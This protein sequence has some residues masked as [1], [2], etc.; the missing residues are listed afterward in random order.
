ML[1]SNVLAVVLYAFVGVA[2]FGVAFWLVDRL[3]PGNM[4][5]ELVEHKNVALGN[6]LAGMAIALAVI[7]AA[8]VH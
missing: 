3:T 2:C 1:S 4:W 8:A 6:F 5:Q 7:I